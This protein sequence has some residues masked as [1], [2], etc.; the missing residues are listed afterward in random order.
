MPRITRRELLAAAAPGAA[1]LGAAA[2]GAAP[3]L[4]ALAPAQPQNAPSPRLT[5]SF[6]F[7][8][9]F[10]IGDPSGAE[11]PDFSDFAW[12]SL[13]LPHDWSIEGPADEHAPSA[14]PGG[15]M[16]TGIAWYRKR[17]NAPEAW[18]GK[19]VTLVF[20]GVYH[21]SSVWLNGHLL[22][23][24]PYGFVPFFYE[25]ADF[26]R[27]GAENL[28]AVRVDNSDQTNCR[29]YSGSGIYRHTWVHVLDP[30][31]IAQWG[32][33]VRCSLEKDSALP[34]SAKIEVR[35][36]IVNTHSSAASCS[37]LTAILS[38]DGAVAATLQSAQTVA[39]GATAECV[40][41]LSVSSPRLWSLTDPHLYTVRSTLLKS[42]AEV[43][44]CDTPFG[45]REALFDAERGFLLNGERVKINGVCVHPE[46]GCMGA[47]VPERVWERRLA[48]LKE[49]GCNAIRTSHNPFAQEFL[50][51]CDRMGFLV[52]AEAFDEWRVPKGQIRHGYSKYFNEWHERDLMNFLARDRNHPSIVIWSAGNEIGDQSAPEG[53]DTLRELMAIFHREDPSRPVTAACDRIAS[54]PPS[55]TVRPEFLATLD[56]VGYNY[57]DRWRDRADMYYSIDHAQHPERRVIGTESVGIGGIRGDYRYLFPQPGMPSRFFLYQ[58]N[59][60][61]DAE[62]LW[63]FVR[64]YDYVAGD[65]MWTGIDYLGEAFWPV[66]ITPSGVLD[67]CAFKKDGFYFYQSQWTASPMIHLLPHWNWKGKEGQPIPV[68]CFT[69]CDTVELFLNRKSLGV[70]GYE[71]PRQGMEHIYGDYPPRARV[72]RTTSDLHLTWDVL[73][74]PGTLKA[75]GVKDST[76]AVTIEVSTTGE[77]AAIA[78]STDRS[79]LAADRRDVA[80]LVI[81]IHDD[82]GRLVPTAANKIAFTVEGEGKLIGVDN[83]DPFSHEDFKASRRRA[84]NGLCLAIVQSTGNPGAIKI[85]ASSAGLA[86]ASVSLITST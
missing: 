43:D 23:T 52:M 16:P 85:T 26:L 47:A 9:K 65:F 20:D 35:T 51:L 73:Y 77:P 58:Q 5:Q 39:A 71:F 40:Q 10:Q 74:E 50:D 79:E 57:V 44:R 38:A 25:L 66:R 13:D 49:M 48:I 21:N 64:T 86:P 37:L 70:K 17:F 45:I 22:G 83:G 28:I 59:R 46:A 80:H 1:V 34:V 62:E 18:R 63:Q 75:V 24:R 60:E 4:D 82:Q 30:L 11:Q 81:E 53:V 32:T 56:V 8:W 42:G 84:F 31:H 36:K 41:Q 54:E 12:R 55:N 19:T 15:Y 33:T 7:D 72:L 76:V 67:T 61:L 14:G 69:N 6:D 29:W 27:P 68:T 2:L 78:L 3:Y